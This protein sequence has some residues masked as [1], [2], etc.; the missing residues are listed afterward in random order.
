[1]ETVLIEER[2]YEQLWFLLVMLLIL[3]MN[4]RYGLCFFLIYYIFMVKSLI[5]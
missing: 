1:M 4:A 5:N 2:Y 3:S